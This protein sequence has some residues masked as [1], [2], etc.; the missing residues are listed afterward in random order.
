M[1]R[2]AQ[3]LA[4]VR[5]TKGWSLIGES[6]QLLQALLD[7]LAISPKKRKAD[8]TIE[9][10]GVVPLLERLEKA[11]LDCDG[12]RETLVQRLKTHLAHQDEDEDS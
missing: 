2:C 10:L 7:Q 12:S 8:G 1:L 5:Q 11:D 3:N 9:G 4:A 6:P